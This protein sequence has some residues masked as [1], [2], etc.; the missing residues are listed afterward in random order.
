MK[1]NDVNG[2]QR[3]ETSKAGRAEEISVRAGVRSYACGELTV[4]RQLLDEKPLI[5]IAST[6]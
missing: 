4:E 5:L 6:N 3:K 2:S 1:G